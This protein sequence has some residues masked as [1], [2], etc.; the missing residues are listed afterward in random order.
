MQQSTHLPPGQ[1]SLYFALLSDGS[2]LRN[3]WTW[4]PPHC[5]QEFGS[6]ASSESKFPLI[7]NSNFYPPSQTPSGC[8]TN[9]LSGIRRMCC[10]TC[11]M[12]FMQ[13]EYALVMKCMSSQTLFMIS[14]HDHFTK[15]NN[16]PTPLQYLI[17]VAP[18]NSGPLSIRCVP[19][20]ASISA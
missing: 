3:T 20:I 1:T 2:L 18:H 6:I 15:Y 10:I 19:A 5:L 11:S 7:W 4:R 8:M 16:L 17:C 13:F 12:P 9:P 14:G